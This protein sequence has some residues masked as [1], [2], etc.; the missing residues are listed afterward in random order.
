MNHASVP[1]GPIY[2]IDEMFSDPQVETLQMRR[3]VSRPVL[4]QQELV[5]QGFN[6]SGCSK[7]IRTAAPG[8]GE[9]NDE[10]LSTFGISNT[11]IDDLRRDGVI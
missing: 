3:T 6:I 8:V 7:D 4:G 9:H 1:A 5:A 10:V 2:S 11:E